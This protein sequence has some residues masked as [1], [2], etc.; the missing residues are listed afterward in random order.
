[1]AKKNISTGLEWKGWLL[2][3]PPFVR[4]TQKRFALKTLTKFKRLKESN[5]CKGSYTLSRK[6]QCFG[7]TASFKVVSLF[8]QGAVQSPTSGGQH[9]CPV[10]RHKYQVR[11]LASNGDIP[12]RLY[13]WPW[14]C[15]HLFEFPIFLHHRYN[16]HQ[17]SQLRRLTLLSD[18]DSWPR[19]SEIVSKVIGQHLTRGE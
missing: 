15:F 1:M 4:E 9:A 11:A 12:E 19:A 2:K 17:Q 7:I 14:K 18:K 8:L 5:W 13:I 6:P 10:C 3:W 16:I